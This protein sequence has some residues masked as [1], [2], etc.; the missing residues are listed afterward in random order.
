VQLFT[1][2]KSLQRLTCSDW[3]SEN[4]VCDASGAERMSPPLD[5]VALGVSLNVISPSSNEFA[6]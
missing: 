2:A 3:G 1:R 6:D 4:V 5:R